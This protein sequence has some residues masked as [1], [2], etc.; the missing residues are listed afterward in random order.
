VPGVLVKVLVM[1]GADCTL[2][3]ARLC[4]KQSSTTAA[5]QE[6]SFQL[7]NNFDDCTERGRLSSACFSPLPLFSPVSSAGV[8]HLNLYSGRKVACKRSKSFL[9]WGPLMS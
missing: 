5:L 6:I 8:R 4:A 2:N 9:S 1:A 3:G 7:A